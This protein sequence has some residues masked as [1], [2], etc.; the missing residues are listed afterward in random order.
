MNPTILIPALSKKMGK[1][2]SLTILWQPLKEKENSEFKLM[3]DLKKDGLFFHKTRDISGTSA[4]NTG[5]WI[6]L[7]FL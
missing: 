6:S 5:Y 3:V 1:L 2:G 7:V 4:A